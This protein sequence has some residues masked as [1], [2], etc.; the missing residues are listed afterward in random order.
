M[1]VVGLTGGI[2]AGKS[3]VVSLLAEKGAVIVDADRI[4]HEV[5]A[6]GGEA[7]QPVIDRFGPGVVSGDGTIDRAAVAAIV[8]NDPAALAD[9][10][11]ITWPV[12]GKVM[13][14]RVA[15]GQ[16]SGAIVIMDIPLLREGKGGGR[17][18]LDAVI[19]VD[20][21][22][23]V[24]VDRLVNQRGMA[25]ADARARIAN[26]AS[27]EERVAIADHVIDNAGTMKELRAQVDAVWVELVALTGPAAG[28]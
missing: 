4:A 12:I 3:T 27:R 24:A 10:Q 22:V 6:P 11:A 16:A 23:E 7:Y 17:Y 14:E 9:Q 1:A 21:P 26:Q 19:V 28:A 13:A 25:E 20:T 2:G 8:F 18:G 15:E 5:M